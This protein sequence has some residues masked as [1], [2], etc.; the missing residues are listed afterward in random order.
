MVRS[1]LLV[2]LCSLLLGTSCPS[3]TTAIPCAN[4]LDGSG[5]GFR[6]TIP[7]DYACSPMF[8]LPFPDFILAFVTYSHVTQGAD[9]SIA[10]VVSE[11]PTD[12]AADQTTGLSGNIEEIETLTN[13][14]GIEF[15][16]V[17]G[18]AEDASDTR[19]SYSAGAE[20]SDGGNVLLITVLASAD[21][22]SLLVTLK[23]IVDTVELV[24]S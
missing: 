20:L 10:I 6:L 4:A 14:D 11:P 21:D 16:I 22:A 7:D 13:P 8:S 12:G 9:N 18:T 2:G 23:G 5:F 24:G 1:L 17:R 15:A 19:V 3:A